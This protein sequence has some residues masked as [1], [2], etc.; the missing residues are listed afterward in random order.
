MD[1]FLAELNTF[2]FPLLV[3]NFLVGISGFP[4]ISRIFSNFNDKGYAF[5]HVLSLVIISFFAFVLSSAF[6]LRSVYIY[7]SFAVWFLI[8]ALV[9]YKTKL[10]V[11]NNRILLNI[12]FSQLIF[13]A[14]ALLWYFVRSH[15]PEVY[16]I[17]RFM[18]FG[19]IKSLFESPTLPPNDVWLAG[20][21]VNYYYFGHFISYVFLNLMRMNLGPGFFVLVVWIFGVLGMCLYSLGK[22]LFSFMFPEGRNLVST[23]AGTLT[24]FFVQFSGTLFSVRWILKIG[25]SPWYPDPTRFIDNTITE[26]PIYSFLV[27]DLHAHVWGLLLGTIYLAVIL[28][29]FIENN[30]RKSLMFPA[31]FGI[32]MGISFMTNSWDVLT[33]GAFSCFAFIYLEQDKRKAVLSILASLLIALGVSA[34]WKKDF[35]TPT[36]GLGVVKSPSVVWKWFLYW[37]H[38]VA[39]LVTFNFFLYRKKLIEKSRTQVAGFV[40]MLILMGVVFLAFMEILYMKDIMFQGEWFRANTVFKISMQVWVWLGVGSGLAFTYLFFLFRNGISGFFIKGILLVMLL[41]LAYYPVY[42]VKQ[43]MIDGKKYTGL[44]YGLNWMEKKYPNDYSAILFMEQYY[45]KTAYAEGRQ[46][47][48]II[49]A[50]GESYQDGNFYSTFLGWPTILGWPG[51]EWTWRN[52]VEEIDSRRKE[53]D[54]IYKSNDEEII[55]EILDKYDITY[56]FIGDFER[57][58]YSFDL[59]IQTIEKLTEIVYQNDSVSVYKVKNPV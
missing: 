46:Q 48:V 13:I 58:R 22:N 40:K 26:M 14:F 21:T 56:I 55:S 15:E 5:S 23:I 53:V 39:I 33:L 29:L 52:N 17:E 42:A 9:F 54:Q 38:F 37:G 28:S 19:L 2:L 35:L 49:E 12:F 30:N 43:S 6:G 34:I 47:P 25:S 59:N 57:I 27:S 7:I 4:V 45:K 41:I 16:S 10:P 36:L 20:N 24:V 32:L 31:I 11:I 8:N 44:N 50:V 18:D 1:I 3:V 51:H